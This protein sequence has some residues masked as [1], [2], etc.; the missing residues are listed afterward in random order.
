M[1]SEKQV[2]FLFALVLGLIIF[3]FGFVFISGITT[4]I[5]GAVIEDLVTDPDIT[6][7]EA[8][9]AINEANALIEEMQKE[10]LMISSMNDL[11]KAANDSL[12]RAEF[13]DLLKE[14]AS[15]P[16]AEQAKAALEDLNYAG[17]RYSD[18][19]QYTKKIKLK[20]EQAFMLIDLFTAFEIKSKEY[21]ENNVNT[22]EAQIIF[23]E[24]NNSF[25]KERYDETEEL[26]AKADDLLEK[27]RTELN[28][29]NVISRLGK[30]F[31]IKNW[32]ELLIIVIITSLGIWVSGKKVIVFRL[33]RK[34]ATMKRE[35]FSLVELIKRSQKGRFEEGTLSGTVY[36]IR[37]E[38]YSDRINELSHTLPVLEA[39][40]KRK[41]K[42]RESKNLKKKKKKKN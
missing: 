24:A 4:T 29:L 3:S 8:F 38:K 42:K 35:K 19:L 30:S 11:L 1:K 28:T 33:R 16:L 10:G 41:I 7:D 6:F 12:K 5:T 26:L 15:G 17:F 18:V 40:L 21:S 31:L 27:K 39:E 20:K 37:M 14:N 36:D 25:E 22:T 9:S 23:L 32:W 34:I 13:A 2:E